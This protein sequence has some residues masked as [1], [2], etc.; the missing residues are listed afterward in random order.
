M[1]MYP[2]HVKQLSLNHMCK[3]GLSNDYKPVRVTRW[4]NQ[5]KAHIICVCVCVTSWMTLVT[6][7]HDFVIQA[8]PT[9]Y[10][11]KQ[12]YFLPNW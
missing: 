2:S 1:V 10:K 6:S 8:G 11:Q 3:I 5:L 7:T 4:T 12:L 9:S